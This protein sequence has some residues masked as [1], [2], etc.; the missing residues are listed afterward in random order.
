MR[1]EGRRERERE[2]GGTR[3]G[4]GIEKT[5]LID[6]RSDTEEQKARSVG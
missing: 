5:K 3:R 4:R 2:G 6:E 1:K